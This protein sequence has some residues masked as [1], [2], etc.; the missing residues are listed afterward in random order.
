MSEELKVSTPEEYVKLT[1]KKIRVTSGAVFHI[2]AM[3]AS[4][5]VYLLGVLPEEGLKDRDTLLRFCEEHFVGLVEHVIQPNV[6]APRVE[7]GSLFFL[8][9]VDL[10]T[11][12]MELS[13]FLVEEE[14]EKSF[15]E[16]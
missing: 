14:A 10:L 3:N 5:M 9:V 6:I 7:S 16:E 1:T 11:G 4:S 13:G 15:P 2:H 8:D 12:L